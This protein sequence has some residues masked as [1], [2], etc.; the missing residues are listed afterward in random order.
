MQNLFMSKCW[1]KL[2]IVFNEL[3]HSLEII[4][5]ENLMNG[6]VKNN[7]LTNKKFININ[8]LTYFAATRAIGRVKADVNGDE[9][10]DLI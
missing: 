1:L 5:D 3:T 7:E 4:N 9:C 6:Q 2:N 8:K 10:I